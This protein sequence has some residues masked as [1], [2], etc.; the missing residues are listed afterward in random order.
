MCMWMDVRACARAERLDSTQWK[1]VDFDPRQV[2]V[3]TCMHAACGARPTAPRQR[4]AP[5]AFTPLTY[6]VQ[7]LR[8]LHDFSHSG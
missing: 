2:C 4:S 7:Q 1:S 8:F 6:T 5:S 3:L